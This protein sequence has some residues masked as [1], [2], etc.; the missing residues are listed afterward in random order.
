MKNNLVLI[1]G[2]L[3]GK[4][5]QKLILSLKIHRIVQAFT[6]HFIICNEGKDKLVVSVEPF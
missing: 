4:T 2:C 6:N 5:L 3:K 1:G